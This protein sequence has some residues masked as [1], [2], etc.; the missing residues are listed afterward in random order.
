[1]NTIS[2]VLVSLVIIRFNPIYLP[3]LIILQIPR[4]LTLQPILDKIT[5]RQS[6][7]AKLSRPWY[8][9]LSFLESVTGSYEARILGIRSFVKNKLLGLREDTIGLF[10]KTELELL[11][12]RLIT[13]VTPML[14]TF[15]IGFLEG[16]KVI[17]Q[18]LSIG[19]WQFI[20]NTAYRVNEQL[21][22]IIDNFGELNEAYAF[23]RKLVEVLG[24]EEI[25][26]TGTK[27]KFKTIK[28]IE[29]KNVSFSYPN[30]KQYVL[31]NVSFQIS[32]NENVAIIGYNG[33]GKTTLV[34]LLCR[35]Y[36][37]TEGV[38]KVN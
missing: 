35:F 7:S 3:L 15:V 5:Y 22:G 36:K 1:M 33:A 17:H 6:V 13:S 23:I 18:E 38:I 26:D 31:K 37:P 8:I 29:F 21:K 14:S 30:S 4:L 11:T 28:S 34:K 27:I 16:R 24:E 19:N 10:E 25:E 20:F 9:Y 32:S 12:S 2:F